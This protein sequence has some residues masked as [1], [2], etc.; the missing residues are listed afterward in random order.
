MWDQETRRPGLEWT[1]WWHGQSQDLC[2]DSVRNEERSFL[3]STAILESFPQSPLQ[4]NTDNNSEKYFTAGGGNAGRKYQ[5]DLKSR[6]SRLSPGKTHPS[7]QPFGAISFRLLLTIECLSP[8]PWDSALE[9]QEDW[10]DQEREQ[11][12]QELPKDPGLPAPPELAPSEDWGV[13]RPDPTGVW[14]DRPIQPPR[15]WPCQLLWSVFLCTPNF[16]LNKSKIPLNFDSWSPT[17]F[18]F[19]LLPFLYLL[20]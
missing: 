12:K 5:R 4:E 14:R 1:R 20:P 19:T 2:W 8:Y 6:S 10:P 11:D 7:A 17:S 18:L 16:H 9:K 15:E 13:F 3:G